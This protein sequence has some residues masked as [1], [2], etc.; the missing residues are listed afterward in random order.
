M[1]KLL[2]RGYHWIIEQKH[3]LRKRA[4][5]LFVLAPHVDPFYCGN[6]LSHK[7][8]KWFLG[9]WKRYGFEDKTGIHL[10]RVHYAITV[11][12]NP[13]RF[14]GEPYELNDHDWREML[15]CSQYA[16]YL[17][18]VPAHAFDDH[19]NAEPILADWQRAE[20]TEPEVKAEEIDP[21]FSLPTVELRWLPWSLT[22][23]PPRV[24]GYDPDDYK[25]RAYDLQVWIEK[26]TMDDILV[27]ICKELGVTYVAS[28]GFQS[29]SN[30][31]HTLERLQEIG[32]PSR[33]FYISDAD[34]SGGC[35]PLAVARQIEFW[36]PIYAPD[37]EVKLI[38]LALTQEQ[39]KLYKLPKNEEGKVELDALEGRHP[40][41][42][43][44]I[45]RLALEAY[46]DLSI[47]DRLQ[48]AEAEAREIARQEWAE[49]VK[50][51]ETKLAEIHRKVQGVVKR[52]TKEANALNKRMLAEL[53]SLKIPAA[54][55]ELRNEIIETAVD[56]DPELPERPEPEIDELD[57]SKWLL[58]TGRDYHQQLTFYKANQ[59][60]RGGTAGERRLKRKT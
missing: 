35:M 56:F 29:I 26:S 27:P 10:R 42:L 55:R 22:I 41:E 34:K 36:Q 48:G 12:N 24:V 8:A 51:H 6:S 52:Y 39:I 1:S 11:G 4:P 14:Q 3:K 18:Y 20:T 23:Q 46:V 25:D 5:E 15:L 9:I 54:L 44:K 43:A 47:D 40:G 53:S 60:K 17:G 13:K 38:P 19:N 32:K 28:S 31:V 45:V 16:R 7:K 33:I 50:A 57:E 37:I 58:D 30:P 49:G 59:A 21:Y 2:E